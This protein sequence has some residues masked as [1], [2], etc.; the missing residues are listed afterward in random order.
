MR[1]S[2]R[3]LAHEILESIRADIRGGAPQLQ[4]IAPYLPNEVPELMFCT[5]WEEFVTS[6][7]TQYRSG[8]RQLSRKRLGE[9]EGHERRGHLA[10]LLPRLTYKIDAEALEGWRDWLFDSTSLAPGSI[11]HVIADVGTCLR[12]L[13]RR[14]KI[15]AVPELPGVRIPEH[16]PRIPSVGAQAALLEAIPYALRGQYLARGFMGLRPSEAWRAKRA[17]WDRDARTLTVHGKGDTQRTLP[18]HPAVEAWLKAQPAAVPLF[19]NPRAEAPGWWSKSS[20]RRVWLV[21]RKAVGF[22][23]QENESLRHAFGT[24]LAEDESIDLERLSRAMGHAEIKTTRR[25]AKLGARGL[26]DIMRRPKG[27]GDE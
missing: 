7:R 20:S 5:H 16:Q 21:A 14:K 1:I 4:A 10:P 2:S 23:F 19:A 18:M 8:G 15:L 3:E 24:H 13:Q 17:D 25:Y 11:H 22:E 6:K 27:G 26:V 12:W 9:F